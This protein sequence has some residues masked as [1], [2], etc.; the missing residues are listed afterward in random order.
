MPKKLRSC[1]SRLRVDIV[2]L[3]STSI[4]VGEFPICP[5]ESVKYLGVTL[6]THL[7]ISSNISKMVTLCF[8]ALRNIRS[9]RRSLTRKLNITLISALVL[10]RLDYCIALHAD[11]PAAS[12]CRLQR[13]LHA[14]ARLIFC[15]GQREHVTPLLRQLRWLPIKTRNSCILICKWSCSIIPRLFSSAS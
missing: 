8:S 2:S 5:S 11:L 9:N 3:S 14:A 12:T 6:D 4:C 7:S 10:S 15:K 13:V 1:G